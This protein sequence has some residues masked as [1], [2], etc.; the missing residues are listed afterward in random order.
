ML[1]SLTFPP[2]FSIRNLL[3]F[4]KY[5]FLAFLL[6]LSDSFSALLALAVPKSFAVHYICADLLITMKK[7]Y[8]Q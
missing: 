6:N 4:T 3:I 8:H 5:L 1:V 7:I 2:T